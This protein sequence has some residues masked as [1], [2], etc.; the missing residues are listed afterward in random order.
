MSREDYLAQRIR[1]LE[2]DRDCLIKILVEAMWCPKRREIEGV[3]NV[4][5]EPHERNPWSI[6]G[7]APENCWLE[8]IENQRPPETY[9]TC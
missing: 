3:H 7:E 2:S 8:L 4:C 9:S 6:C 5:K 1:N